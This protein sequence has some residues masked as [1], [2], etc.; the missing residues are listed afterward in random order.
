MA[1]NTGNAVGSTSPKDLSDNSRN[2][3]LLALGPNPSYLDRKGVP[4]KSWKGM[5]GEHSADQARREAS[6]VAAQT[7]RSADFNAAQVARQNQFNIYLESTGFESPPL[8]YVD[9]SS[10]QVTRSTQ[11]VERGGNLY[12]VRLPASFPYTLSGTWSVDQTHLVLRNDQAVRQDLAEKTG[13]G[14]VGAMLPSGVPGTV[15]SAINQLR[16]RAISIKSYGAVGDGNYYPVSD[17]YLVGATNYRC[18]ASLAEVQV[19]YPHVTLPTQSVDWAGTQA[20]YNKAGQFLPGSGYVLAP[21]GIY[22]MNETVTVPRFV[23]MDGQSRSSWYPVGRQRNELGEVLDMTHGTNFIFR[24]TGTITASSNRT[25]NYFRN[26]KAGFL[27]E[28][29]SDGVH[30]SNLKILAGFD[31]RDAS[32]NITTQ[33]TDNH[34][35]FDV[36]IWFRDGDD[37]SLENVAVGGYWN[38]AGVL[39]DGSG[40]ASDSQAEIGGIERMVINNCVI[41]GWLGLAII[42][43][44]EGSLPNAANPG[45]IPATDDAMTEGSFGLSHFLVSNTTLF[46]ENH[47]SNGFVGTQ[48]EQIARQRFGGTALY[49]DGRVN[50]ATTV[51]RINNP[52]FINCS[53]QTNESYSMILDNVSR[54]SFVNCRAESRPVYATKNC[55][56]PQVENCEFSYKR[57]LDVDRIYITNGGLDYASAPAVTISAPTA[58]GGATATATATVAGGKVLY[59]T[60]NSGGSGYLTEPTITFTG[61]GGSGATARTVIGRHYQSLDFCQGASI[62]PSLRRVNNSHLAEH[63]FVMEFRNN[64]GIIE[65]RMGSTVGGLL[66]TD[67]ETVMRFAC[68]KFPS[69]N[70]SAWN[71]SPIPASGGADDFS[72]GVYLGPKTLAAKSAIYTPITIEGTSAVTE[73]SRWHRVFADVVLEKFASSGITA[74]CDF[75]TAQVVD[76]RAPAMAGCLRVVVKADGVGISLLDLPSEVAG[77]ATLRLHVYGL[78]YPQIWGSL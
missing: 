78:M 28:R 67:I 2:L 12:S 24:G 15:Q 63:S 30:F 41:Q 29:D 34:A 26:I 40:R 74:D 8:P 36:G 62:R 25:E 61:G 33:L 7:Q 17:W 76:G 66:S 49:I 16:D 5:E 10:L 45:G 65:H 77:G 52:R 50:S 1:Y 54:P 20:A 51:G 35:Q 32:N 64:S 3:D 48:A 31:I 69:W 56:N 70:Y 44:D 27:C 46:G 47:H 18:Y 37:C 71:S 11:L 42:G 13:A 14:T 75:Y 57:G 22:Y 58:P 73:E 6:F 68:D 19:H 55:I 39:A 43:G 23:T 53:I 4:R 59:V 60:I 21:A 38:T 72:K 9:S